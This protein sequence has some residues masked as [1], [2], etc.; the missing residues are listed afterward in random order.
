M[1]TYD[2]NDL[3]ALETSG[4]AINKNND[5]DLN[6]AYISQ[7]Q[8]LEELIKLDNDEIAQYLTRGIE[9]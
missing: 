7:N 6:T 8:L 5:C 2:T 3:V 4:V 1:L 9:R